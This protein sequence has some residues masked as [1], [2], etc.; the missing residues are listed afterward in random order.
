MFFLIEFCLTAIV[1][2]AAFVF[3]T[4]GASGF[5][6]VEQLFARLASRH[7]LSVLVVGLVALAV[8]AALLPILPIPEPGV[9]DEFSYLLAADT[10]AHGRLANPTHPMWVHL[11]TFHVIQQP[12][13]ASKYPPAQGLMLA[14]GQVIFGHP[15][16][17][18]WLSS[19]LLCATMCWMLQAWLPEEW[20]LLGGF[21]AM[22]RLAA[23]SYWGNSYWGGAVAA[24]GGALV[25]GGL[26][27][28]QQSQ[29]VRD[30]LLIGLGL[31]ILA[32]SR[33]YEGLVLSLPVMVALLVWIL[34][35]D[36]PPLGLV[37]RR[38]LAPLTLALVLAGGAMGYYCWRITGNP[39]RMPFQV[40]QDAYDPTP[41][42]IWQSP[43][44]Q[45]VYHHEVMR[46]FYATWA[47]SFT[48]TRS[49]S[50]FFSATLVK[51][52]VL[53]LFY[54]GPLFTLTGLMAVATTPYGLAWKEINPRTRFLLV[55]TGLS[56]AGLTFEFYNLAHYAAPMTCL[57]FA[58]VLVAMR[59]L[60]RWQ[61]RGKPTGL[62]MVRA[63]TLTCIALFLLR[64]AATPLHL[65]LPQ[66][67]LPTWCTP[68][69]P[70]LNRAR[71]L[72]QLQGFS[73]HHLVIVRYSPTHNIQHEWVHNS[74]DIDGSKVVWA[75]DMASAQNE[76]LIRYFRDRHVWV[77]DADENPPSLSPYPTVLSGAAA[78][79]RSNL[80]TK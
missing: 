66:V 65:S 21:L 46:D 80:A 8:R 79:T 7:G 72:S 53:W 39:F 50:G 63:A 9:H 13:Y 38:V 69:E 31:A 4:L 43:K 68:G 24:T 10:F 70:N 35:K 77:V 28:V 40:Y 12:T 17:G 18:V 62:A 16:W 33:P 11:E 1:V 3:P 36:R 41:Y 14:L 6:K 32:N 42:L 51:L 5:E 22:M 27:R 52:N 26:P 59:Y 74:A 61:W 56:F 49:L 30:A 15:F 78:S 25:L 57:I 76:E 60:Q 29:R 19:G 44:P 47:L 37:T 23:F 73:G 75:R 34:G 55:A 20:A 54:L 64:A 71:L 67:W 48:A 2:A 58:L 45:P